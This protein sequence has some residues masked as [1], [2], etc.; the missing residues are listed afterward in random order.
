M[1]VIDAAAVL[2][3]P[4]REAWAQVPLGA[5]LAPVGVQVAPLGRPV[6]QEPEQSAVSQAVA[7]VLESAESDQRPAVLEP[8]RF[9]QTGEN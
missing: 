1:V 8:A 9:E 7:L 3:P 4:R 2:E 6:V 5:E